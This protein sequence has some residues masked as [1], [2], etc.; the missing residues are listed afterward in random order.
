MTTIAAFYCPCGTRYTL[1]E[2][3]S[4]DERDEH[5]QA[6][7]DHE[8]YCSMAQAGWIDDEPEPAPQPTIAALAFTHGALHE[9]GRTIAADTRRSPSA[10][11]RAVMRKAAELLADPTR[12]A[13]FAAWLLAGFAE[14]SDDRAAVA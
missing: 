6:C 8:S 1:S 2:G 11:E 14:G 4:D 5:R 12:G 7:E 13:E 3:A 9:R 10:R